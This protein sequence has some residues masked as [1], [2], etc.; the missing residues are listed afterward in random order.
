MLC[1]M[2]AF[3]SLETVAWWNQA[4]RSKANLLVANSW[5]VLYYDHINNTVYFLLCVIDQI[6][7]NLFQN[8]LGGAM[9]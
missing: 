5:Y 2:T 7:I 9:C 1:N 6:K 4:K 8:P 3:H